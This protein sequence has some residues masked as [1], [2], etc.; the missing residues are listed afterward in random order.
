MAAAF[1]NFVDEEMTDDDTMPPT[2]D[3]RSTADASS[4]LGRASGMRRLVRN[5]RRGK[6]PMMEGAIETMISAWEK[7]HDMHTELQVSLSFK[8]IFDSSH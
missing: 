4:P 8:L 7:Y 6:L 3:N 2:T 5:G 1:I